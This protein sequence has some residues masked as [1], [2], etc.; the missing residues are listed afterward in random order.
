MR[1]ASLVPQLLQN[2]VCGGGGAARSVKI[3]GNF[4]TISMVM[5][6]IQNTKKC[7]K[8][9]TNFNLTTDSLIEKY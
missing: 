7:K 4:K 8:F 9:G 3:V 5:P 1:I 6:K 2:I